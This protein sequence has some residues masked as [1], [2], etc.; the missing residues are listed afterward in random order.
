MQNIFYRQLVPG[1]YTEYRRLRLSCLD[2][3]PDNFGTTYEEEVISQSLKLERAVKFPN[4]AHFVSGAFSPD[5]K[6]IAICGFVSETRLKARHRGE[7]VQMFVEPEYARQGIGKKLLQLTIDKAFA[8]DQTEQIILSVVYTNEYAVALYK[9]LGFVE[10]GR[11][12]NYF[13]T[14]AIYFT[15]LFLNLSK[16]TR[17]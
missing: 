10:Y 14:G 7:I 1:D 12:A 5:E 9:Q 2:Q 6:L 16:N 17:H 11:L 8:N 4:N 3:F 15:Q 13:K